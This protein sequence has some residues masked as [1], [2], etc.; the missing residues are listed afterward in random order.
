MSKGNFINP[1][2]QAFNGIFEATPSKLRP[3]KWAILGF[4]LVATAFM[5]YGMTINLKMDMTIDSWFEAGDPAK[6][7]LDNF[8][9]EFGS[10]DGLYVIYKPKDGDVFSYK[11]L[12]LIHEL[13]EELK[14]PPAHLK[15]NDPKNLAH[16]DKVTS[17]AN[18]RYQMVR[19]DDLISNKMV[20]GSVPNDPAELES[21]R[22]IAA[23]QA[24]M[25][26]ALF[27]KDYQYGAFQV[28][29]DFGAI[30][31]NAPEQAAFDPMAD[32]GADEFDLS[33]DALDGSIVDKKVD[34]KVTDISD[35][36][37][38][39]DDYQVILTQE[40]YK[41]QF[42]FYSVGNP[43]MM[44]WAMKST[45]EAGYLMMLMM[46]VIIGLLWALLHS[47]S[48]VV[49]PLVMII[50]NLCWVIGTVAWLGVEVTTLVSLTAMLMITAGVA[51]SVH[52]MSTYLLNRRADLDHEAAMTKTYRKTGIPILITS[53][54]TM[55]G[56]LA[57][58]ISGMHQFIVFGLMSAA[59]V[60]FAWFLTWTLLPSCLELWHP[61]SKVSAKAVEAKQSKLRW[62]ISAG[63]IQP[64]LDKIPG[65]VSPRPYPIATMFLGLLALFVYGASIVKVD[66][67]MVELTQ[68][69]SE[70]RVAYELVDEKMMGA[71]SMEVMLDLGSIDALKDPK[72]LAAI[73]QLEQRLTSQYSQYVTKT[74]S[75]ARIVKETNQTMNQDNKAF[76]QLPTE[77]QLTSQLIFLFT[78]ANP[79]DRRLLVNDN[80][81]KTH[82]SIMLKNAGSYEYQEM[83]TGISADIEEVFAPLKTDYPDLK[84]AVTGSL[85][86]MMKL[87][88][89]MAVAQQKSFTFVIV[90]ISLLMIL[91]LGS[92]QGGLISIIPNVIPALVTFGLMGLLKVPLDGDTM[93]IAPVIIGLAVDDTIH[94]ITHYRDSL[95]QGKDVETAVK[96]TLKEVGQAITFTSLILGLGFA[97]LSFST[98]GGLS[99]MGVFGS[100]G[101]FAALICDL[102]LLPALIYIFKPTMGTQAQVAA[103]TGEKS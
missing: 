90:I 76:Y 23:T 57:L 13:S 91:T 36:V 68:E 56:M 25:V 65:M 72:V 94:F 47:F 51:D 42:E 37:G 10:D 24:T 71:Q 102:F 26:G 97:M 14:N 34:F 66:T 8:R 2:L 1:I 48:A 30:P 31:V 92:V 28:K 83:F 85:A 100:I 88:Q 98:Y 75:L 40:K 58:S 89:D 52:V 21:L 49:W 32:E 27:S 87:S 78:N 93:V 55:A 33:G 77:A 63:W 60:G 39:M 20:S 53:I 44:A 61:H 35:Y 43:S 103:Q 3:Y 15:Y 38:F 70:M 7:A 69:G 64:L 11:S 12:S 4:Y 41:N 5:G 18:S 73:D 9:H 17:L 101:I 45:E 81:S 46:V 99:K 6:V 95:M 59:G 16:I 79:E 84:I 82:I 50:V 96:D 22:R 62:F 86:M 74:F 29:T 80:M 19:G 67:N 54:T